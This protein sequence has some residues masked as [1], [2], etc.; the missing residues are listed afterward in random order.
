LDLKLASGRPVSEYLLGEGRD[1]G[2]DIS[3]DFTATKKFDIGTTLRLEQTG[4]ARKNWSK[5]PAR[6]ALVAGYLTKNPD[7]QV[8]VYDNFTFT[9]S[10]HSTVFSPNL[11]S[12][13]GPVVVDDSKSNASVKDRLLDAV[14]TDAYVFLDYEKRDAFKFAEI[15]FSYATLD[16][17]CVNG[18][19]VGKIIYRDGQFESDPVTTSDKVSGTCAGEEGLIKIP[20]H[21]ANGETVVVSAPYF[22]IRASKVKNKGKEFISKLL[23]GDVITYS[24]DVFLGSE[25]SMQLPLLSET[26]E[27]FGFMTVKSG[28]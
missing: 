11:A 25:V 12:V 24:L 10:I 4:F 8:R 6:H 19:I 13:I 23:L 21:K 22:R 7:V 9:E 1:T 20:L 14:Y 18:E 15:G 5:I 17:R 27:Y 2:L 26:G 28:I 16:V 3:I